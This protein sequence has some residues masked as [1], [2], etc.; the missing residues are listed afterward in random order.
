VRNAIERARLRHADR[1]YRMA[2][3]DEQPSLR[4]LMRIEPQDILKSSVFESELVDEPHHS[5]LAPATSR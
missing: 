5:A 1:V 3:R 4:D 2:Q